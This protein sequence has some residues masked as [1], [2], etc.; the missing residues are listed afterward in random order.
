M[1]VAPTTY[2]YPEAKEYSAL[3]PGCYFMF[4]KYC[5][6]TKVVYSSKI[7]LHNSLQTC[8]ESDTGVCVC[9]CHSCHASSCICHAAITELKKYGIM[10][11]S[12][13]ILYMTGFVEISQLV[14]K[15]K[16]G[17]THTH[18]HKIRCS[19]LILLACMFATSHNMHEQYLQCSCKLV[20][21][22]SCMYGLCSSYMLC[23][24]HI[25]VLFF[26]AE[27]LT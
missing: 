4:Y 12:N 17:D 6:I 25:C 19:M 7:C 21:V 1:S 11:A 5:T 27:I 13:G 15:L 14:Q 3:P 10:V 20:Q 2:V 26:R 18:T 9:V 23:S 22:I 8:K 24:S 16:W